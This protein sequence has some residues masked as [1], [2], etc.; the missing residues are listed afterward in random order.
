M[1]PP[2]PLLQPPDRRETRVSRGWVL[3]IVAAVFV[4]YA[5]TLAVP[6]VFDDIAAVTRNPSLVSLARAL[7]PP[8]GMSVTGRPLVNLTLAVNHALSGTVPWSYHALNLMLHAASAL[9]LFGVVR[10]GLA[11]VTP[12]AGSSAALSTD[13]V[14]GWTALVWAVH[15]LQSAS[16]TYVMQRSELLASTCLLAA[17]YAFARAVG[18]GETDT[19]APMAGPWAAAA[20]AATFAG[21]ASKE[22]MAGAPLVL[23]LYDRTFVSGS[24]RA[25]LRRRPAF[26]T[27][28]ASSWLL[29]AWLV[30]GSES[31]GASAGFASAT[32]WTEYAATQVYAVA[33]YLRLALW[34]SAL[35][36]DYGTPLITDPVRLA[37]GGVALAAIVV[38]TAFTWHRWPAVGF[39]G[40]TFF[41][42]L[43]PSSSVVPI[44]TQTIAEHRVYLALALPVVLVVAALYRWLGRRAGF[45]AAAAGAVL[46]IA[47][48]ARN[49][50]YAT[51]QTL[52][53]DTVRKAPANPRAHYN[54]ALAQLDAGRRAEALDSLAATTRLAAEHAAAH[55]KRGELLLADGRPA[56]ALPHLEASVRLQPEAAAAHFMVAHAYIQLNR[57]A[58]ALPRYAEAVRLAP[59]HA[60]ARYNLGN[61]LAQ[62]GRYGEALAQ[63]EEASRL[64]PADESARKNASR[65]R[66][67]L[68]FAR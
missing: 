28:L 15:P 18:K 20:V 21:M 4:A 34:P 68:R 6:F 57:A 65:I 1:S 47:T 50:D 7:V 58:D 31:R 14:A 29:L 55:Q 38:G 13:A 26:Y 45:V 9:L 41:V 63:F 51:V 8:D 22:V 36:F 40:C 24:V 39:C 61:A 3:G 46:L 5:N 32:A 23:L 48:V 16:V 67:Y 12:L 64:D 10:R 42:L 60:A 59:T 62:A 27:A 19:R 49:R 37:P 43:A 2:S 52:W 30:F 56:D 17:L 33:H 25:A 11:S 53:A 35:V 54:L 66:D 44:A